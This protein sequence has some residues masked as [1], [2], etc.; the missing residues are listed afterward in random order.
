MD[1]PESDFVQIHQEKI[2]HEAKIRQALRQSG[3]VRPHV[4]DRGFSLLGDTLIRM[5]TRLKEHAHTRI[6]AEEASVPTFLI[7]L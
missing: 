4:I 6:I 2:R 3:M 5:G 7:M 1:N